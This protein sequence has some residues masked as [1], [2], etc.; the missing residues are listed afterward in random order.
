MNRGKA[1]ILRELIAD[2]ISFDF[3][4]LKGILGLLPLSVSVFIASFQRSNRLAYGV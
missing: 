2:G 3:F 1:M 4:I